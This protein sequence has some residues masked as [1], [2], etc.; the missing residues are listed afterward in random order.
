VYFLDDETNTCWQVMENGA[1]SITVG[2][3]FPNG[4]DN[5]GPEDPHD[6]WQCLGRCGA[7]CSDASLIPGQRHISHWSLGCFVHDICAY[8]TGSPQD[9]SADFPLGPA[10][11]L[12]CKTAFERTSVSYL[13]PAYTYIGDSSYSAVCG[14]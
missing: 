4:G 13:N 1:P 2:K 8:F 10:T 3:C 7:G 12:T 14:R 6:N 5:S 9:P 11:S